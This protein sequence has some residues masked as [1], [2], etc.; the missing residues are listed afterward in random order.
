MALDRVLPLRYFFPPCAVFPYFQGFAPLSHRVGVV[1]PAS[2]L[3][4]LSKDCLP[5]VPSLSFTCFD[6]SGCF[7]LSFHFL[8]LSQVSPA[9]KATRAPVQGAIETAYS[10]PLAG[11][12]KGQT[13]KG[14]VQGCLCSWR[15]QHWS[16]YL[17]TTASFVRL[18]V[19]PAPCQSVS[20]G[21]WPW[22]QPGSW[23]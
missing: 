7:S 12:A 6:L 11:L 2:Q 22:F 14:P 3:A 9:T 10:M 20:W 21:F 18:P 13:T 8:S 19:P 17:T 5:Q 4:C 1:F 16:G 15:L 23:R